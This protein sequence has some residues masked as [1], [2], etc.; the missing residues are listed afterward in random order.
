MSEGTLHRRLVQA[1]VQS[2]DGGA[3]WFLFV[4][5]DAVHCDGCPPKLSAVRP[6]VYARADS[7]KHVVIGEAKT[8]GDLENEHTLRQL[9]AYFEHLS[10]N[11]SSEL[12]L[13]VPFM[14]AGQAHRMCRMA[15][16]AAGC[17]HVPFEVWGWMFGR[18]TI[19]QVWRG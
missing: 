2:L 18:K 8:A 6:D 11:R 3:R 15:R 5:G 14:S 13:A 9:T 1:L 4:D 16:L 10:E 7:T 17:N 12:R 19:S